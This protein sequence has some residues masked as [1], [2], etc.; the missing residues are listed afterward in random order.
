MHC[1]S[2]PTMRLSFRTLGL[3][4]W[5]SFRAEFEDCFMDE[6]IGINDS[7]EIC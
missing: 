1:G 5:D 7:L 3:F 2:S 6:F 4:F